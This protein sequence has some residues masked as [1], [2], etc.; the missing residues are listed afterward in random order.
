MN[1]AI[2]FVDD[3]ELILRSLVMQIREH[4]DSGYIYET[5]RSGEEA[6][7]VLQEL[8]SLGISTA[9][10]I[11]DWLMPDMKGDELLIKVHEKYPEIQKIMLTGQV[12]PEAVSNAERNG[13]LFK[14]VKK[15]WDKHYLFNVI[16]EAMAKDQRRA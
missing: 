10:I 16:D 9:L 7:D 3:E 12:N 6:L 15:P 5:A 2:L 11:S 13:N 8:A 4:F 14:C 1:R